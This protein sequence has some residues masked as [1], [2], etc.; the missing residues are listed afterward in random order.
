[1]RR[2]R[3]SNDNKD[4]N[5]NAGIDDNN[6]NNGG[7]DD[8]VNYADFSK[9]WLIQLCKRKDR[10]IQIMKTK[11]SRARTDR[12]THTGGKQIGNMHEHQ[13]PAIFNKHFG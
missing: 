3:N 11:L 8:G 10:V 13:K 6:G 2:D 7:S 4:S 5:D 1:M 12:N 9:A